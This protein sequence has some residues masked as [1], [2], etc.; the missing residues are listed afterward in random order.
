MQQRI[1]TQWKS[2]YRNISLASSKWNQVKGPM[3]AAIATLTD[4]RWKPVQPTR[5]IMRGGEAY[6]DFGLEHGVSHHQVLHRLS[7]DLQN[8]LWEHAAEAYCGG[9]LQ[10][11]RPHFGPAGKAHADLIKSGEFEAARALECIVCNKSWPGARLLQTEIIEA[12]QAI[13]SRCDKGCTETP[14]HRYYECEANASIDSRLVSRTMDLRQRAATM[15]EWECL[16][17][18]GILQATQSDKRL[19]GWTSVNVMS[20]FREILIAFCT[21]LA[22]PELMEVEAPIRSHQN[23]ELQP[24][25]P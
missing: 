21:G 17:F 12:S 14:F 15:P 23:D 24:E 16:W 2:V 19:G 1:R 6:A 7:D 4:A 11:G 22:R 8:D 25:Q 9:G 3:T 10:L 13:C 18:R 20:M 5:W